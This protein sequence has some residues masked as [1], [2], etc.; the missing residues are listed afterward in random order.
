MMGHTQLF[1]W[2]KYSDIISLLTITVW[3][4]QVSIAYCLFHC[5]R[6]QNASEMDTSL[7]ADARNKVFLRQRLV[8]LWQSRTA[9]AEFQCACGVLQILKLSLKCVCG[10][11][12]GTIVRAGCSNAGCHMENGNKF[13]ARAR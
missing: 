9:S 6:N 1:L 10:C 12:G 7:S 5:F 11:C 4:Y 2:S 13:T 8:D 3:G